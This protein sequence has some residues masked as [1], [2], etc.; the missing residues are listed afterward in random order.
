LE[1]FAGFGEMVEQRLNAVQKA[2]WSVY[3]K[4]SYDNARVGALRTVLEALEIHG[5]IVQT[6]EVIERLDRLEAVAEERRNR[7]VGV[8]GVGF[9]PHRRWRCLP[10]LPSFSISVGSATMFLFSR[11]CMDI[12]S[13]SMCSPCRCNSG[14]QFCQNVCAC[15]TQNPHKHERKFC[16]FWFVHTLL[17]NPEP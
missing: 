15:S 2:A 8:R 16:V 4:A 14:I 6:R 11:C 7:G 1:R 12:V 3:L 10:Q 5:S 17:T 13:S 9:E